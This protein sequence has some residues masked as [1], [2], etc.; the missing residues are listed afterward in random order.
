M[1]S[2]MF[3]KHPKGQPSKDRKP[4]NE[5]N[6]NMELLMSRTNESNIVNDNDYLETLHNE[7]GNLKESSSQSHL[8]TDGIYGKNVLSLSY[9]NNDHQEPGPPVITPKRGK[10]NPPNIPKPS[11][12]L[13]APTEPPTVTQDIPPNDPALPL[14]SALD[15]TTTKPRI[16]KEQIKLGVPDLKKH[17]RLPTAHYSPIG[18]PLSKTWAKRRVPP[19]R[20]VTDRMEWEYLPDK[21]LEGLKANV[22]PYY[23]LKVT[24]LDQRPDKKTKKDTEPTH[25]TPLTSLT[26]QEEWP[27]D[28]NI[29]ARQTN[30]DMARDFVSKLSNLPDGDEIQRTIRHLLVDDREREKYNKWI[31]AGVHSVNI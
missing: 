21:I 29:P 9:L 17:D 6:Q 1:G 8:P 15:P 7:T 20:Q 18:N 10:P 28:Q 22:L 13:I 14:T 27:V 19:K 30:L 24:A 25:P 16:G 5:I 4:L 26:T 11:V 12:T 31:T 3:H 2:D 23:E